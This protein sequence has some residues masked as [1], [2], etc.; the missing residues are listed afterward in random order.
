[1]LHRAPSNSAFATGGIDATWP[2]GS[3]SVAKNGSTYYLN[4]NAR[5]LPSYGA[6]GVYYRVVPTP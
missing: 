4:G 6:N 2:A 3:I 1:V 5:C